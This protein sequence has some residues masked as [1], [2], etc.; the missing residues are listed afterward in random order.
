MTRVSAFFAGFGG[1]SRIPGLIHQLC[2]VLPVTALVTS[3]VPNL[4]ISSL[5]DPQ[6]VVVGECPY[7]HREAIRSLAQ[8][9]QP[10]NSLSCLDY[11]LSP[12]NSRDLPRNRICSAASRCLAHGTP[13]SHCGDRCRVPSNQPVQL[14]LF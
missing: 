9:S 1:H 12:N 14:A 2:K 10:S 4:E 5:F 8:I 13:L 3:P 6:I 7:S 11:A